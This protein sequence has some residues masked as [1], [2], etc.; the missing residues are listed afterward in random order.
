MF[1][2]TEGVTVAVGTPLNKELI[3]GTYKKHKRIRDRIEQA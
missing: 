3:N 1:L 2:Q